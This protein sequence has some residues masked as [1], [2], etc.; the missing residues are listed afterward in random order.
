M[1]ERTEGSIARLTRE[2]ELFGFD[3]SAMGALVVHKWNLAEDLEEIVRFHHEPAKARKAGTLASVVNLACQIHG[4]WE[5]K[6]ID[7]AIEGLVSTEAARILNLHAE[8][9]ECLLKDYHTQIGRM[10]ELIRGTD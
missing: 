6:D 10:Q 8:T 9:L 3:H 5:G 7:E 4:N 1:G 2:R